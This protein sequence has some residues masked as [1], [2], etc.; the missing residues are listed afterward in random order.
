[1]QLQAAEAEYERLQEDGV[2]GAGVVCGLL[3]GRLSSEDK[4]AALQAFAAGRTQVL[5]AT[6]V[7]EVRAAP[8]GL[9]Y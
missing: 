3:H 4:I 8:S 5:I 1:M 2:L 7:V 9:C 6:S